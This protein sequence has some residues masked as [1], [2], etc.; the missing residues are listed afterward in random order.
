M[1]GFL[2]AL[3]AVSLTALILVGLIGG[4]IAGK[5]TGR[6]TLL[7]VVVGVVG[8][9]ALPFLL[10][11]IGIGVVAAGGLLLLLLVSA[12]GAIALIAICQLLFGERR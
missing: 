11:A 10:A 7:Y 6:N 3:G 1:E 12:I 5:L 8:A 4:L 9:I 2:D